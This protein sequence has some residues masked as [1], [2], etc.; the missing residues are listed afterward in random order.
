VSRSVS[1]ASM[2]DH[3]DVEYTRPHSAILPSTLPLVQND[4]ADDVTM[5][6][7]GEA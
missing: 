1:P 7:A 4:G 3:L 2:P 5:A 6:D